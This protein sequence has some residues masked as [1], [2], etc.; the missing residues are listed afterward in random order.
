MQ[1]LSRFY[2][3]LAWTFLIFKLLTLP[4]YGGAETNLGNLDKL[5]HI[6][7]FAILTFLLLYFFQTLTELSWSPY[8]LSFILSASYAWLLEFLQQYIPGRFPSAF[9]LLAAAGGSLLVILFFLYKNIY[10][11]PKLLLHICCIGCGAFVADKLKNNYRP[12][13]FFYNPN[14]YPGMEYFK[15]LEETKRVARLLGIKVLVGE[16]NHPIWRELVKGHEDAPERGSR[17]LICYRERL[18]ATAGLAKLKNYKWFTSTLT[19]SPHKLAE[20]I[21]RIGN[22]LAAKHQIN[23]LDKD[24]KKED[25]FKKAAALSQEFNLYRQ[26]YCGCEFSLRATAKE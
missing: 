11:K 10:K 2:L 13:L 18:E 26:D 12:A 8:L 7:L 21:S 9:D 20:A 4:V 16:Y 15:R 19:V 5:T 17:C 23:F 6:F 24:F 22:E 3:L 14:I 1:R 25:G